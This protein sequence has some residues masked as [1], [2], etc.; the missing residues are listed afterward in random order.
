MTV[1]PRP[2]FAA[3]ASAVL[4]LSAG[5]CAVFGMVGAMGQ[6]FE[7]QKLIEVA[8]EY[9]GL[10][11]R[12]VAV[13]VNVGLDVRWSSPN[14]AT[15]V[16]NF[17]SRE[18]AANVSG[19]QVM[20]P[21]AVIAWQYRTAQW[22]ALPYGAIAEQLGVERVVY[23]DVYEYRLNPPG[24]RYLWEGVCAATVGIIEADGFDS[25]SFVDAFEVSVT[26]P[27]VQGVGRDQLAQGV[28]ETG[29]KS[30]FISRVAQLFYLHE[31]PKYPDLYR[32]E[33]D[34]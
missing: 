19:A 29:L 7:S 22:D 20:N 21:A 14:L 34:A 31:R 24:N 18:I 23:V 15:D 11:D 25:D 8:P 1:R 32:P 27:D 2:L 12:T 28:V 17:V 3:V 6:S 26:H 5:G 33:L 16:T 4:L 10:E 13:V 9:Y 30:K